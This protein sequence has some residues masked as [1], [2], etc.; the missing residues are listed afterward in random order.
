MRIAGIDFARTRVVTIPLWAQAIRLVANGIDGW[1]PCGDQVFA[2]EGFL[3]KTQSLQVQPGVGEWDVLVYAV[4]DPN[5]C[6][7]IHPYGR[8][9][10][11]RRLRAARGYSVRQIAQFSYMHWDFYTFKKEG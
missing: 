4:S 11:Y 9:H 8:D 5:G 3:G 2:V 10:P 6:T 7:E 1:P